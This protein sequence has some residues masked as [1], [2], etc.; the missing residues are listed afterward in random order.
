MKKYQVYIEGNTHIVKAI[1]LD[2]PNKMVLVC[3][4]DG[5]RFS[6][7]LNTFWIPLG[8][9]QLTNVIPYDFANNCEILDIKALIV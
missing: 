4:I 7:G 3:A 6:N 5:T 9:L 1:A 2:R 8:E